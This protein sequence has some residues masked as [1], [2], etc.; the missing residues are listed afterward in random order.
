MVPRSDR[1]FATARIQ[2][3]RVFTGTFDCIDG[4]GIVVVIVKADEQ[5]QRQQYYY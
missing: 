5:Q 4:V 2:C 1:S 3:R